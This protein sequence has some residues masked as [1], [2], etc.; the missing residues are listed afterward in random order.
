MLRRSHYWHQKH[1]FQSFRR[2]SL[3]ILYNGHWRRE[4]QLPHTISENNKEV[5]LHDRTNKTSMFGHLE[6]IIYFTLFCHLC[7]NKNNYIFHC[8]IQCICEFG[9]LELMS[10]TE[11]FQFISCVNEIY[12]WSMS[13]FTYHDRLYPYLYVTQWCLT[14]RLQCPSSHQQVCRSKS[15]QPFVLSEWAFQICVENEIA[16]LLG[17]LRGIFPSF[18]GS[19][20]H[21][22]IIQLSIK[23]NTTKVILLWHFHRLQNSFEPFPPDSLAQRHPH[24][25][26][27]L[28]TA[29]NPTSHADIQEIGRLVWNKV[30]N[31]S[32]ESIRR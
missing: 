5:Y 4:H 23:Q 13:S 19:F 15:F 12:I 14:F 26:L 1:I 21:L 30:I 29:T 18:L 17:N 24:Y 2:E 11:I 7:H 6:F 32:I 20:I 28:I 10:N 9:N 3:H 31:H 27:V 16:I 25:C 8:R 22:L